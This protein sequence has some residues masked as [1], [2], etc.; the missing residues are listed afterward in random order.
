MFSRISK[1]EHDNAVAE[2]K[3]GHKAQLT[4]IA[5]KCGI[6]AAELNATE[7]AEAIG[8][9]LEGYADTA[10]EIAQL[11]KDVDEA[12]AKATELNGELETANE[13]LEAANKELGD[14]KA[15]FGADAEA[16]DFDLVKAVGDIAPEQ[17]TI[18]R[19][20]DQD[21]KPKMDEAV[22]T[23]MDLAAAQYE[24]GEISYKEYK[25]RTFAN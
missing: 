24:A 22:M 13:N 20:G 14:V 2:L 9:K 8:A 4:A 12:Q 3:D 21:D 11:N 10:A 5:A 17:K 7:L 18:P 25:D 16:A 15:L 23:D 6:D 19:P 1:A